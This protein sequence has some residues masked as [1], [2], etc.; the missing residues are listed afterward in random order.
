MT[1]ELAT[2]PSGVPTWM[3]PENLAQ[4]L[5][6]ARMFADSGLVPTHLQD[7][8]GGILLIMDQAQR[9]GMSPLAVLQGSSVVHGKLCYEGKLVHAALLAAGVIKEPLRFDYSGKEKSEAREVTISGIL[10]ST[11]QLRDHKGTVTDWKT[12]GKG[13]PWMPGN[14]DKMLAYRGTREWARMHAPTVMV[15]VMTQDE[16]E[17]IRDVAPGDYSVQSDPPP[18]TTGATQDDAPPPA[19]KPEPEKAK[20]NPE[21]AP[22]QAEPQHIIDARRLFKMVHALDKGR[23]HAVIDELCALYNARM[24]KEIKTDDWVAFGGRVRVCLNHLENGGD[25]AGLDQIIGG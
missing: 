16:A 20:P 9:W 1:N 19:P 2:I 7:N 17:E 12:T 6:L 13:S 18:A 25:V 15:G 10:A 14:Y 24:P 21:P 4:A 5:E 8:P 3:N 11:G 22:K 23:A